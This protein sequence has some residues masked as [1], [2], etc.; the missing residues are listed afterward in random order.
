M[1]TSRNN[2][3]DHAHT[4]VHMKCFCV[5]Y[6]FLEFCYYWKSDLDFVCLKKLMWLLKLLFTSN[7]LLNLKSYAA[8]E[9]TSYK[10]NSSLGK[11]VL[12]RRPGMT[13]LFTL[14]ISEYRIWQLRRFCER[15]SD[16]YTRGLI[17]GAVIK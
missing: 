4:R 3:A 9:M 12:K 1:E 17:F 14:I 2:P 11:V 13:H 8:F 16:K 10:C 15:Q 5:A 7:Q 6:F